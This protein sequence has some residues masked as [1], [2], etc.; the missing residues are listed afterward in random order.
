[1]ASVDAISLTRRLRQEKAD[2]ATKATTRE[3]NETPSSTS[4]AES[5]NSTLPLPSLDL[6]PQEVPLSLPCFDS[7]QP[8][9]SVPVIKY[10][11]NVLSEAAA[12]ALLF[13]IDAAAHAERW[14]Q[15]KAR[16]LQNWGGRPGPAGLAEPEPLP[17]GSG[18]MPHTDGPA[19][20]PVSTTL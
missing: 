7:C 13:I 16:R 6:L 4:S 19:Y 5:K 9:G 14:V 10:V 20:T 1:M 15:L 2:K 3:I 17:P 12:D 11:P 18:I 8:L